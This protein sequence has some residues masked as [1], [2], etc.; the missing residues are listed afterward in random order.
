MS[1][2]SYPFLARKEI[3]GTA[4]DN[5]IVLGDNLLALQSL[6]SSLSGKITC[7][8]ADPPYNTGKSFKDYRDNLG[9][10]EWLSFMKQRLAIARDLLSDSGSLWITIDDKE[11]HYLKV[12]CDEI[13]G[14]AAFVS[15]I[16]WERKRT[17]ANDSTWFS[18]N[19]DHILVYCKDPSIWRPNRLSRTA[20]M[21]SSYKNPDNHKKGVW[22]ST[23]L[24]TKSGS[25]RYSFTFKNGVTWEPPPNKFPRFSRSKLKELDDADEIWFGVNGTSTPS[26][27]TF[28]IE[29]K[30]DGVS[31][32][33]IWFS[34]E[35]GDN[36]EA[37][38]EAKLL[39]QQDP[40][41]TPKPERLMSRILALATK[42]N[43]LVLDLFAGS[44]TFC[45]S[46]QK[47]N[48]RWIGLEI[49]ANTFDKLCRRMEDIIRG[50]CPLGSVAGGG[51]TSFTLE[52]A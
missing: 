41:S 25:T 12:L 15:N 51:F 9:S 27:K 46:A 34:E 44:G 50:V 14:R 33:S 3:F 18:Q 45:A 22:K 36:A 32:E 21:D 37:A 39:N 7:V 4:T 1:D 8:F 19:H 40:F 26:R 11:S 13:F 6:K 20:E 42:E 17:R 49:G 29:L 52:D 48:R 31:A 23:P 2:S 24:H 43:D 47:M 28:L 38:E 5:F 16:I 30:S 35:V 10:D